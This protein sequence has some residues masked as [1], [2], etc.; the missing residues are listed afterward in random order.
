MTADHV[1]PL[2]KGGPHILAN[3]RPACVSCNSRKHATWAGPKAAIAL[4]RRQER[5]PQILDHLH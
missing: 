2:A 1:K 3:I 4:T 5:W